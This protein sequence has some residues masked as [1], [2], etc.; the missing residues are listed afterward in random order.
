MSDTPNEPTTPD[1]APA[2]EEDGGTVTH[3]FGGTDSPGEGEP[4]PDTAPEGD[5][6]EGETEPDAAPEGEP[7]AH[8]P[9]GDPKE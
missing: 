4:T 5:E 9:D 6:P 2:P 7:E 1:E 8:D 3:T